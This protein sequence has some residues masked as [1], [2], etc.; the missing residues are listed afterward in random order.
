MVSE[1]T[2]EEV[3]FGVVDSETYTKECCRSYLSRDAQGRC[4]NILQSMGSHMNT[5]TPDFLY[6]VSQSI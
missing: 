2:R 5:Q 6:S 1:Y 3:P 4:Y